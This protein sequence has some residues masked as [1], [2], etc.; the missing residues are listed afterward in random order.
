MTH[1]PGSAFS[2]SPQL[3]GRYAAN[4][5]SVQ[6]RTFSRRKPTAPG[7]I[8]CLRFQ[9]GDYVP[10]FLSGSHFQMYASGMLLDLIAPSE[11]VKPHECKLTSLGLDSLRW[12]KLA[13]GQEIF[14]PG[15]RWHYCAVDTNGTKAWLLGCGLDI[16]NIPG[17]NDDNNMSEILCIDLEKFGLLGNES[18]HDPSK[19]LESERQGL[20]PI[21]SLGADLAAAF[22]MPPESGSET[23]FIVTADRDDQ[24]DPEMSDT[25][26][27]SQSQPAFQSPNATTSAPIHVHRII[28]QLRWPHFKRLYSAQ[29]AEYHTKR[30]H[31]P[32]PYSVVRAFLYYLYTDSISGH[33]VYCPDLVDVAG[34]LVMANLYDMPK[35]RLL[36]V[37]RLA[38]ELDVGN[39]AIVWERAGRT[40][41][42]WLMHRAA[43]FCLTHWGRIVR[44]DGFR[45]L[46]RQGLIELCE[47]VDMEGRV[48]AGPEL[49][50]AGTF[51]PDY[52]GLNREKR[53]KLAVGDIDD[54]DADDAEG[55]EVS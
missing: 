20:P 25:Q 12:Q 30:V 35:L 52:L 6:V 33:P 17:S 10:S 45:S 1:S 40:N 21:S 24:E 4:S 16:G 8:S 36:C 50:M 43:Q 9:S 48:V 44:T 32:E 15:Y 47:M 28:L 2:Q 42:Q 53:P 39:A 38:R 27:S 3:P 18:T 55:M 19:L 41:E 26:P 5:G 31:I 51:G 34:M 54:F 14:T 23:D 11:S 13:D 46:S 29:M 22:D 7:N 37:N 49:E